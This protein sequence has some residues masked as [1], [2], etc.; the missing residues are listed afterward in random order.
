MTLGN[1]KMVL[2]FSIWLTPNK[3]VLPNRNERNRDLTHLYREKHIL[4]NN[5]GIIPHT[6]GFIF[7]IYACA[8]V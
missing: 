8:E 5:Q 6:P 4:I 7:P 2:F 1:F 3:L